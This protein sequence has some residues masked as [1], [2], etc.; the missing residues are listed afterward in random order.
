MHT[1]KQNLIAKVGIYSLRNKSGGPIVCGVSPNR[2]DDDLSSHHPDT[3]ENLERA[4]MM[5]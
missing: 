3:G 5:S 4:A 2:D 1:I